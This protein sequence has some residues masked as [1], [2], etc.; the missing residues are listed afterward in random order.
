MEN[1]SHDQSHEAEEKAALK[2][3][4]GAQ[5][6][7]NKLYDILSTPDLSHIICWAGDGDRFNILNPK[8]FQ[9]EVIPVYF[10]HK[11]LK[12]FVRQLNLHGFKKIRV[13]ARITESTI[14]SYRHTH[15]RQN[16]PDL[17]CQIKRKLPRPLSL[18]EALTDIPTTID[19]PE[20]PQ[21]PMEKEIE[22]EDEP[23]VDSSIIKFSED[24]KSNRFGKVIFKSLKVFLDLQENTYSGKNPRARYVY[25]TTLDYIHNISTFCRNLVSDK[26]LPGGQIGSQETEFLGKRLLN[27]DLVELEIFKT[28]YKDRK[29]QPNRPY[30]EAGAFYHDNAFDHPKFRV[31]L[32]N[33][34]QKSKTVSER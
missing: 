25:N 17:V 27:S 8:A 19:C 22:V 7:L 23:Y 31:S 20:V 2:Q 15:F 10:K 14:D 28:L 30:K 33:L 12:S 24:C 13:G 21:E 16:R 9:E 18:E 11:N 6:F 4:M 34:I 3:G 32:E 29:A 26:E 5:F 1:E